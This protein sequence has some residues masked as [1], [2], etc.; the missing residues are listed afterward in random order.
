VSILLGI[1]AALQ[2][3]AIAA[4]AALFAFARTTGRQGG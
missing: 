1:I 4:F 2:A 3:I